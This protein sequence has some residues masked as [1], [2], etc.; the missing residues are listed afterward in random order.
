MAYPYTVTRKRFNGALVYVSPGAGYPSH[1]GRGFSR[2]ADVYLQ[3][4]D[5]TKAGVT[6]FAVLNLRFVD[7]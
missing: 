2:A 5:V 7:N 6:F 3:V 1:T 4:F